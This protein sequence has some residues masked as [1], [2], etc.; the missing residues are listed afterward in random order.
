[1]GRSQRHMIIEQGANA[2]AAIHDQGA[3]APGIAMQVDPSNYNV[4]IAGTSAPP[5]V[6]TQDP[7]GETGGVE[8]PAGPPGGPLAGSTL[9]GPVPEGADIPVAQPLSIAALDPNN[10]VIGG[11]D[12]TMRVLG[13]GFTEA[14]RIWFNGGEEATTFLDPTQLSTI[15]K[16]STA[17]VVG[18]FPVEVH[19]GDKVSNALDFSFTEATE[20]TGATRAFPLGPALIGMVADHPDG[21]EIGLI[22][23]LAIEVGDAVTIEATGNTGVNG[24]YNVLAINPLVVDNNLILEAPIE[25]KGRLTVTAGA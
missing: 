13:T 4:A 19:D 12:V 10:A 25:N 9:T 20:P 15:V 8:I 1:M 2:A 22:D 5:Y 24:N 6:A 16:P 7:T 14:S 11:E 18:S 23:A 3:V 17:T 21:L